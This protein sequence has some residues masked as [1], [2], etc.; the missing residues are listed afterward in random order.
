MLKASDMSNRAFEVVR[1]RYFRHCWRTGQ[2]RYRLQHHFQANTLGGIIDEIAGLV[3]M[4]S[5]AVLRSSFAEPNVQVRGTMWRPW[6]KFLKRALWSRFCCH[7][8][9]YGFAEYPRAW[10]IDAAFEPHKVNKSGSD[11]EDD[12]SSAEEELDVQVASTNV[13]KDQRSP[14]FTDFLQFLELGCG[15]S[16]LQGYPAVLVILSSI[17]PSVC[18]RSPLDHLPFSNRRH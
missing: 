2:V 3:P 4:L 11:E 12:G 15:G 13:A 10:E 18:T 1:G 7:Q 17:P 5:I 8:N 14:G 16:P 6:L 9:A